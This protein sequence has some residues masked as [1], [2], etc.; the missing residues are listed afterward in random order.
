MK[1][2]SMTASWV[3]SFLIGSDLEFILNRIMRFD[4]LLT[5]LL[6]IILATDQC[7]AQ[8]LVL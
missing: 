4:V 7:N 6:S 2:M 8:I 3:Q 5:M 1:A